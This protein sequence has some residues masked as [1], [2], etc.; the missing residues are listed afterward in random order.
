MRGGRQQAKP[1]VGRP[2]D[3][4]VRLGARANQTFAN[5]E[6]HTFFVL[7][8]N[9]RGAR[10]YKDRI[11]PP[12]HPSVRGTGEA[13][14]YPTPAAWRC[15]TPQ[16]QRVKQAFHWRTDLRLLALRTRALLQRRKGG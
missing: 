13:G 10:N 8:T 6:R 9:T 11:L 5:Y 3:G 2:L 4:R 15:G 16:G 12:K 14:A 7:P 1:D